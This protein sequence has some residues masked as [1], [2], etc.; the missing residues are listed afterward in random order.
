MRTL[1]IKIKTIL[2]ILILS[3][4]LCFGQSGEKSPI[5]GDLI[6]VPG[7]TYHRDY[8][9]E[10][11]NTVD[12]FLIGATEVTQEQYIKVTGLKNPSK[13]KKTFKRL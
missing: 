8:K 12:T 7:G 1:T 10:N 3:I 11:T 9:V 4:N 2:A 13:N 5:I 6:I